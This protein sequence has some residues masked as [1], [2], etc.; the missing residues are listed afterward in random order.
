MGSPCEVLVATDSEALAREAFHRVTAEAL[1][2]EGKFSRY[3]EGSVV[4]A[5]HAAGGAEMVLDEETVGILAFADQAY[6]LSEGRFDITS[7]LLRRVWSF[8]P[9]SLP[10]H[11]DAVARLLPSIGWSSV[12]FEPPRFRLPAGMEID[13]GGIGKEYAVDR[14]IDVLSDLPGAF[15][16]NLGGDLRAEHFG[17]GI[18]PRTWVVGIEAPDREEVSMREL[19]LERGALATSGDAR[20]FL[21]KDGVRYG[22]VLDPR[23]GWPVPNAPRSVTVHAPTCVE[24]GFLSTLALLHGEEAEQFL[25]A[26]GLP[27]WCHRDPRR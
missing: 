22:H 19:G 11:P 25:E 6:V 5:I 16:V 15:L 18:P 2:I 8:A 9:G 4:S 17:P 14:C 10:P 12:R 24:A 26:Q 1:R 3:R 27:F 23:T 21:Q 20:R 13:L 7:G